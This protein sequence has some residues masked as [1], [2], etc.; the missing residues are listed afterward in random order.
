MITTCRK[1]MQNLHADKSFFV[2]YPKFK[3]K[4]HR[5]K[6]RYLRFSIEN[7]NNFSHMIVLHI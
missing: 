4:K 5:I 1:L 7:T 3:K 6:F 2:K